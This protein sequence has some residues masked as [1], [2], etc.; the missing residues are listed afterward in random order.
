MAFG[1]PHPSPA[2]PAFRYTPQVR[3]DHL[4]EQIDALRRELREFENFRELWMA[5]DQSTERSDKADE[6]AREAASVAALSEA[7]RQIVDLETQLAALFARIAE[8]EQ[9]A[10]AR[11]RQ[12]EVERR[13]AEEERRKALNAMSQVDTITAERDEERKVRRGAVQL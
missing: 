1:P 5:R 8:L 11:E 9:E 12:L 3:E 2:H 7:H 10:K 6:A 13:T 4:L